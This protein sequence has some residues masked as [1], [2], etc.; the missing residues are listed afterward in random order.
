MD[1]LGRHKGKAVRQLIRAAVA[2]AP[3]SGGRKG[4]SAADRPVGER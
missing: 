4:A 1:N 3:V 2:K